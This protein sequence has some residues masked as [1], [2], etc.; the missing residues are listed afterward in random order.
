MDRRSLLGNGS[1]NTGPSTKY[2]RNIVSPNG[3]RP[4][5]PNAEEG[6]I[7]SETDQVLSILEV[8]AINWTRYVGPKSVQYIKMGHVP[9]NVAQ[10]DN[11]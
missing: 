4:I 9:E 3:P 1:T 5:R 10:E 7:D 8:P 2:A 6:V 11:N